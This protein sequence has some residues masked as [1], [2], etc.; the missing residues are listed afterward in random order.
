MFCHN[1][2]N[3]KKE[4]NAPSVS[5]TRVLRHAYPLIKMV[6]TDGFLKTG[7][8]N[9]FV[10]DIPEIYKNDTGYPSNAFFNALMSNFFILRNAAITRSTF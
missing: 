9:F 5:S 10:G 2:K 6:H 3:G 4:N 7:E 8:M 1:L